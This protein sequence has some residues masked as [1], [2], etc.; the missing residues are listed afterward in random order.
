VERVSITGG[1]DLLAATCANDFSVW[2]LHLADAP[3][4]TV[5]H[6]MGGGAIS[7]IDTEQYMWTLRRRGA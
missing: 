6:Y 1:M 4:A 3:F 7:K 2:A 5:G